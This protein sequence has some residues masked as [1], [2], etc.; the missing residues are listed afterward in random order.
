[1]FEESLDIS[2]Q[3]NQGGADKKIGILTLP[4]CRYSTGRATESLRF[5]PCVPASVRR[6]FQIN[7]L[8]GEKAVYL[9]KRAK[10]YEVLVFN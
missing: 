3:A 8:G 10:S 6:R 7:M 5:Q 4:W 2:K 9:L 1:M